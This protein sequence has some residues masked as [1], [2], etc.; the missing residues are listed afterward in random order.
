MDD[1]LTETNIEELKE[2]IFSERRVST[3]REA[4]GHGVQH[5]GEAE[6]VNAEGKCDEGLFIVGNDDKTCFYGG[7][8]DIFTHFAIGGG[9]W[10]AKETIA[11]LWSSIYAFINYYPEAIHK[12]SIKK[13]FENPEYK[14]RINN[15]C[16]DGMKKGG[17]VPEG[18]VNFRP[19]QVN[20]VMIP[21]GMNLPMHW[22][23]QWFWGVNQLSAPDWLLHVMKESELF[24]DIMI[25]QAQGV[26]YLHGTK[27]EPYYT[28]GGRY[29]FWPNGP[30]AEAA[31]LPP[32]RGQA[33]IMDGGRMIHG[34]ERTKPGHRV[35]RLQKGNFNRIEYQGND[36]W[37]MLSN[38]DLIDVWKTSDFR[39]TFVWR[40]LCFRDAAERE[41]FENQL[42][43][44]DFE[45][46]DEFVLA[47]LENDLRER[48]RLSPSESR[49]TLGPKKF[50]RLLQKTYM[51]YPLSSPDAW[52]PINYCALGNG[53]PFI[54]WLLSPFCTDLSPLVRKNED[55]PPAKPFCDPLNREKRM[56]NCP[57]GTKNN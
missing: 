16:K 29:I 39:M 13:L 43:T 45:P 44:E 19:T 46:L 47:R 35:G 27:E 11:K 52:F 14:K 37:Y 20:I 4:A 42:K 24:D 10:G 5:I 1:F 56:T 17:N 41:K 51:Q 12:P 3:A 55:F 9:F 50:G 33:I 53:K 22:D 32:K 36:T 18:D 25:P 48:G 34:V 7:R 31:S 26:A 28:D 38:D 54:E 15:V 23:N 49:G 6:P 21:P 30:G 8:I 57:M 2:W 40:G